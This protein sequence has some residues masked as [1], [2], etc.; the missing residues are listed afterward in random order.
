MQRDSKGYGYI[1]NL[2]Y[3][4]CKTTLNYFALAVFNDDF[5]IAS[6][7]ATEVYERTK[8]Y[9]YLLYK[10]KKN[11]EL[12]QKIINPKI[13]IKSQETYLLTYFL[14]KKVTNS[15][16]YLVNKKIDI[17]INDQL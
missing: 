1:F 7:I 4:N 13:K 8:H 3:N 5:L 11:D 2:M 15:V 12:Y 14:E 9:N 10:N 17:N 6:L 16:L